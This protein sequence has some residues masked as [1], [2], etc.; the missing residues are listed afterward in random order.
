MPKSVKY[1][2]NLTASTKTANIFSG[3]VIEFV[4]YDATV[5]ITAVSSA[6]GVNMSVF[7]D[8][9]IIVDDKEIPF[10]GTTLVDKD[11]LISEFSV[12]AGTRMAI[13]LRETAAA[14]TTDVYVAL[15]VIPE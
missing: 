8:T 11:H 4:P 14:G 13:F 5:R 6:I 10:I 2:A 12:E 1:S 3:D 15:E 9:D 7:A